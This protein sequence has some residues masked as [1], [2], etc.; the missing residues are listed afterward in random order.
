MFV[1]PNVATPV[2]ER[3]S[4]RFFCALIA[5][6]VVVDA[7]PSRENELVHSDPRRL[8]FS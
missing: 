2:K 7:A 8:S 1:F 4:R 6:K 3:L 5:V